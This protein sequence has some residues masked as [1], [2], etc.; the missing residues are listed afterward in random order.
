M[1]RSKRY[2][3]ML[4]VLVFSFL[5][6]SAQYKQDIYNA[7]IN[8]NMD[9]WKMLID[10]VERKQDKSDALLLEL[11]NYQ[12]GYIG[13]CMENR[14]MSEV[15]KYLKLAEKNLYKLEE[16]S[17]YPSYVNA[18]KSAFHG[19]TVGLSKLKAPFVGPK[20]INAA[21]LAMEQNPDNPLGFVQYANAQFYM[22]PLFGGSKEEAI[23]YYKKA[24]AIM[25]SDAAMTKSN[26]NY[27]HLLTNIA[28]A[29]TEMKEY[30][31]AEAYYKLILEVE[32]NFLWVKNEIYPTFKKNIDNE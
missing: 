20:S 15:K 19:F 27:L 30:D 25:E 17:L 31:K 32:P 5:K 11:I 23:E 2:T 6:L 9:A 7:F 13:F 28:S 24:Q 12:Y 29:Y 3:V 18:Y 8:S 21:K 14:E 22:P 16:T 4:L 1:E 26:W 10:E